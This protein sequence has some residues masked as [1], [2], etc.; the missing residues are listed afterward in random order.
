MAQHVMTMNPEGKIVQL[1]RQILGDSAFSFS[2]E[3]RSVSRG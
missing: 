3:S 2:P 1:D